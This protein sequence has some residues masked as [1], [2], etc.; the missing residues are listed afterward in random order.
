MP[1]QGSVFSSDQP[2][3]RAVGIIP[4][5]WGA[6]RFPGKLL[7][8]LAGT[9]VICHTYRRAAASTL[10]EQVLVA[11]DDQRISDAIIAVGGQAVMTASAPAS[12]ASSIRPFAISEASSGRIALTRSAP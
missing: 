10:L 5:R 12:R 2:A 3:P 6:T 9:P 4:A 1:V 11:T 7:A 8:D